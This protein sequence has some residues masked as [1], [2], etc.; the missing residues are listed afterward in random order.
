MKKAVGNVSNAAEMLGIT[1]YTLYRKL[2]KL[3]L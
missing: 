3:G 1:R 2:Q